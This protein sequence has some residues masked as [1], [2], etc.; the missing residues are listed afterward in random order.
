MDTT[1]EISQPVLSTS[2]HPLTPRTCW[3]GYPSWVKRFYNPETQS[4]EPYIE[5]AEYPNELKWHLSNVLPFN[6]EEESWKRNL[7]EKRIIKGK[8]GED[9]EDLC[10]L[11]QIPFHYKCFYMSPHVIY[12]SV[13][14]M[15]LNSKNVERSKPLE[16]FEQKTQVCLNNATTVFEVYRFY[17]CVLLFF[18][19]HFMI[20][21]S[22][23]WGDRTVEV[24]KRLGERL[25]QTLDAFQKQAFYAKG[26]GVVRRKVT[27][28]SVANVLDLYD[29]VLA[30]EYARISFR[31]CVS[32]IRVLE[33]ALIEMLQIDPVLASQ[34]GFL[35]PT[36]VPPVDSI[37][38]AIKATAITQCVMFCSEIVNP[39]TEED[40]Y[41]I[42][43]MKLHANDPTDY[44]LS[45][46]YFFQTLAT[47]AGVTKAS[48]A[49][50]NNS[51]PEAKAD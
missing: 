44:L 8:N 18:E 29:P 46:S 50:E 7:L 26:V 37:P 28:G 48:A 35:T 2:S 25:R 6:F 21:M 47:L 16:T 10:F 45:P 23:V 43:H 31:F 15:L 36:D 12:P 13:L 22:K 32:I 1:Q 51:A 5:F 42:E 24:M 30:N 9:Q 3:A 11:D 17:R 40:N 19:G 33:L 27:G 4:E 14:F 38:D 41:D 39:S 34:N 20:G 49:S